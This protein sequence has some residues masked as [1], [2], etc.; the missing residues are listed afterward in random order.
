M[1]SCVEAG[2]FGSWWHLVT[3]YSKVCYVTCSQLLAVS[4]LGSHFSL[5]ILTLCTPQHLLEQ[6][7][8]HNFA[9]ADV[10]AISMS[11]LY[12]RLFEDTPYLTS[13]TPNRY[14][15]SVA[16]ISQHFQATADEARHHIS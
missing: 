6:F 4:F 12:L 11:V 5:A 13:H 9:C 8:P 16:E 7:S 14:R 10:Q 2:L 15:T 1:E 3:A